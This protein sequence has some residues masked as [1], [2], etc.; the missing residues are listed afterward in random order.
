MV[1]YNV[2]S[3]FQASTVIADHAM[4]LRR[5]ADDI[6][7]QR[8]IDLDRDAAAPSKDVTT[9]TEEKQVTISRR[10]KEKV[11]Q[12][13]L[14]RHFGRDEFLGRINEIVYFLPFS[15]VSFRLTQF[16]WSDASNASLPCVMF[17]TEQQFS[18]LWRLK[19]VMQEGRTIFDE[20]LVILDSSK[21]FLS[22]KTE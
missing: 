6:L 22:M 4:Q 10:F 9:T 18:W 14:K 2:T 11:V 3:N 15:R 12:P 5:D 7:R 17:T 19:N 16:Y 21:I 8:E 1:Q 13:I 20:S